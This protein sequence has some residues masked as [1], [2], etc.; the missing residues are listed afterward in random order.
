MT[1]S[2]GTI[3]PSIKLSSR[4]GEPQIATGYTATRTHKLTPGRK[5]ANRV[6]ANGRTP[7]GHGFAHLKNGRIPTKLRTD[8]A[9]ASATQLPRALLVPTNLKINR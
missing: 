6:L 9:S 4:Q 2:S 1:A 7:G 5:E 3:H 8:P